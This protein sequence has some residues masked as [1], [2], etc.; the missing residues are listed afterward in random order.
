MV[1]VVMGLVILLYRSLIFHYAD[2]QAHE[3]LICLQSENT[4]LCK[5]ELETR[6]RKLLLSK[7][8]YNIQLS[9]TFRSS[10]IKIAIILNQ[11][12]NSLNLP[13]EINKT[14]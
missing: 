1:I 4:H 11:G 2:Y 3:A 13:V 14:L 12:P 5:R 10:K 6:L 9:K 8:T 7:A